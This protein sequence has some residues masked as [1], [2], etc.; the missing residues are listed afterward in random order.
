MKRDLFHVFKVVFGSVNNVASEFFYTS[1]L[2]K[3]NH[4]HSQYK[5]FQHH[6]HPSVTL[7]RCVKS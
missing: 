2:G 5:L 3:R 7:A 4:C 6:D 1:K